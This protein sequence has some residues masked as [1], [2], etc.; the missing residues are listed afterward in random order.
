MRLV[1]LRISDD[2]AEV[3][4]SAVRRLVCEGIRDDAAIKVLRKPVFVGSR[5]FESGNTLRPR[6][7]TILMPIRT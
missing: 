5:I 1:A 6:K 2:P 4:V 3:P 7:I